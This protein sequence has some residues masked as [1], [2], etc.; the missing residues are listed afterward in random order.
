ME[1]PLDTMTPFMIWTL[2]TTSPHYSLPPTTPGSTG[3]PPFCSSVL[4]WSSAF[5]L[6]PSGILVFL[7]CQLLRQCFP[8]HPTKRNPRYSLFHNLCNVFALHA[9][10]TTRHFLARCLLSSECWP[11]RER[12]AHHPQWPARIRHLVSSTG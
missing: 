12:L 3:L 8:D 11:H 5:L 9:C 2:P 10:M 7:K 4:P 1:A 6:P